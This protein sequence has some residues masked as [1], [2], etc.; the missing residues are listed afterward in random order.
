MGLSIK[1]SA[2]FHNQLK[3]SYAVVHLRTSSFFC[4]KALVKIFENS[5]FCFERMIYVSSFCMVKCSLHVVLFS[6]C[7]WSCIWNRA[8]YGMIS[9]SHELFK[10]ISRKLSNL[11]LI[12]TS[13][14]EINQVYQIIWMV[15]RF[16]CKLKMILYSKILEHRKWEA[17]R[18]H[19]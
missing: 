19:T 6:F 18:I 15:S 13:T 11:V 12:C 14:T 7:V 9:I 5:G 10:N 16:V 1:M 17:M 4:F 2:V 3:R 8:Q